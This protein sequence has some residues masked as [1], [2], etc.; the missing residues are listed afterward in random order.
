MTDWWWAALDPTLADSINT[1]AVY[2]DDP[3]WVFAIAY[4]RMFDYAESKNRIEDCYPHSNIECE[5]SQ[6]LLAWERFQLQHRFF[7]REQIL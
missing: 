2:R 3:D 7:N 4:Q 6:S 5:E 1:T